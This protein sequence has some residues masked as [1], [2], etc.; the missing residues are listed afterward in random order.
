MYRY[1]TKDRRIVRKAYPSSTRK[2]YYVSGVEV[3]LRFIF[4]AALMKLA[5]EHASNIF[6]VHEKHPPRMQ[7]PSSS[8]LDV[9]PGFPFSCFLA[10]QLGEN[11]VD[12][13]NIWSSI[14]HL[15]VWSTHK[16]GSP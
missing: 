13:G 1:Q 4:P 15:R 10:S 6:D 11:F 3:V 16:Y 9:A 8:V 14:I 7:H 12:L 2:L 5:K